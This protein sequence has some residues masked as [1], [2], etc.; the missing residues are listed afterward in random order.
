[1]VKF[2]RTLSG[3]VALLGAS[4]VLLSGCESTKNSMPWEKVDL[5][6]DAYAEARYRKAMHYME[7][8]RY[9]LAQQ[10]FAIVAA[11]ANSAQLKKLGLD[12]YAKADT[13]IAV[14]R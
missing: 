6:M 12:G 1:M 2:W 14:K 10:Q 4:F 5:K 3:V 13:A 9:E 11:T 8:S 7:E